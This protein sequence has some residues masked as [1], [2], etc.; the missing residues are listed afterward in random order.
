MLIETQR[1]QTSAYPGSTDLVKE[2]VFSVGFHQWLQM[3]IAKS[4]LLNAARVVSEADGL[5]VDF[6]Y[7]FLI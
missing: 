2:N 4:I 3:P 7:C 6:A 5:G 1:L